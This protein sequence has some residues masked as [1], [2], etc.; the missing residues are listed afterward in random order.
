[1]TDVN[2]SV[3]SA[4]APVVIEAATLA[5]I[6][7]FVW[8]TFADDDR[9][10]AVP[11]EAAAR[12]V[13]GDGAHFATISIGGNWT[14]TLLAAVSPALVGQFAG[15]LMGLA[16]DELDPADRD[17]AFGEL[18]NVVGGNVK[19]LVDDPG[20]TLSLPAVSDSRPTLTGGQLTVQQAFDVGGELMIWEL[21][22]R[23]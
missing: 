19:G 18:I 15:A 9:I 17:D 3:G 8:Q 22:E 1:M 12:C 23:P 16:P 14:A 2:S 20:A 11:G 4:W 21:W 6:V 7:G 5:E 13:P 10:T